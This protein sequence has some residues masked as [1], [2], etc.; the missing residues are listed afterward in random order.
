MKST[1]QN[2][3]LTQK[4]GKDFRIFEL[5]DKGIIAEY[6]H[7]GDYSKYEV[8]FE[9][10]D[11]KEIIVNKKPNKAEVGLFF[12]V[13]IN[14]FLLLYF[15]LD[16]VGDKEISSTTI[17]GAAT[18]IVG[19]V[20]VWGAKL[21]KR[22]YIKHIRGNTTISFFYRKNDKEVVD[23]FI[24]MIKKEKNRYFKKT[25]LKIDEYIPTEQQKQTFLWLYQTNQIDKKEYEQML[26]E[27]DNIR[28][29]K[30]E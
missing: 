29:I 7:E 3:E 18:G 12:S 1:L 11:F 16:Q 9:D 8:E 5:Y 20:S 6:K 30:G 25:Y 23:E 2:K 14:F 22:E 21:F 26:N 17:S 24:E 19:G 10:I 13:I 27:L 15:L 4:S 28:I